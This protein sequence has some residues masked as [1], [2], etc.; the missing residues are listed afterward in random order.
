MDV[1]QLLAD[2]VVGVD[3]TFLSWNLEEF[4]CF[5]SDMYIVYYL[6]STSN[7]FLCAADFLYGTQ[8]VGKQL[9]SS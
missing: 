6:T 8:A 9:A 4:S 7:T 2:H 3:Q 1:A 5:L